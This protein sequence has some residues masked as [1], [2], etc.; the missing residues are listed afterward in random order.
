MNAS[1]R[2]LMKISD[3]SRR[4]AADFHERCIGCKACM[5][6]S[7]MLPLYCENPK[8]L[9][10]DLKEAEDFDIQMPLT[11]MLCGY[12][13]AVC[14]KGISIRDLML[15]LRQDASRDVNEKSPKE[16]KLGGVEWHQRMSFSNVMMRKP[17]EKHDV[18]FF[19]GCGLQA[20]SPELVKRVYGY[21]KEKIPGIG[22]YNACCGKPTHYLGKENTFSRYYGKL[23]ESFE[24]SGVVQVVTGCQNCFVT[25]TTHSPHIE[26]RSLYDVLATVAQPEEFSHKARQFPLEFTLHDP[27]PTR[28]EP[29]IHQGA[30]GLLGKMGYTWREMQNKEKRTLCCGAGAMVAQ[31]VPEVAHQHKQR[32]AQEAD[33]RLIVTY[34]QE[35]VE[36]MREGG[37][38]ALH[39]LDLLFSEDPLAVKQEITP[40]ATK[41][42][43]RLGL[44]FYEG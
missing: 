35:C 38:S 19:P 37:K 36:S 23:T 2:T 26:V 44:R 24:K 16:W 28:F 39:L 25:I 7:P 34:C 33:T 30:R 10:A 15:S 14:P 18:V 21:L 11:C 8:D 22:Y 13:L 43:H 32:R 40:V 31:A 17:K 42:K 41:W 20:Y 1:V 9:F 4:M 27:C 6:G 3:S 12:C 5:K 29:A